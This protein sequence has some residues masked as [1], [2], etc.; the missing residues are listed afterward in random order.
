MKP[1]VEKK[2]HAKNA[3]FRNPRKGMNIKKAKC[4]DSTSQKS[5]TACPPMNT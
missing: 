4:Q 2:R 5:Q 1:M 3:T